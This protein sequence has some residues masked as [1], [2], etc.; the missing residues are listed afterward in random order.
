MNSLCVLARL[1][2]LSRIIKETIGVGK[3]LL[4]Q[5]NDT[6]LSPSIVTTPICS[7]LMKKILLHLTCPG[8][9]WQGTRASTHLFRKDFHFERL[10]P[11]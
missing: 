2:K 4:F 9:E 8:N 10:S 11:K 1:L 3:R 7:T 6:S 5:G